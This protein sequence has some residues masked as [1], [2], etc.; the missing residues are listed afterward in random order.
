MKEQK[1]YNL[2]QMKE[3]LIEI[4]EK[5]EGHEKAMVAGAERISYETLKNYY[6]GKIPFPAM[7]QAIIER[8]KLI[9]KNR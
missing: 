5:L 6:K 3:E 9:I 2:L 4:S 1:T 7:A 8:S